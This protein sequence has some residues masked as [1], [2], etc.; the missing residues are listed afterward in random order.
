MD[1]YKRILLVF[2]I[3]L[4]YF[5][6]NAQNIKSLKKSY[7]TTTSITDKSIYLNKISIYYLNNN[8]LDS[9]KIYLNKLILI[10]HKLN[11]PKLEITAYYHLGNIYFSNLDYSTSIKN[12]YKALVLS[13]ENKLT[14]NLDAILIKLALS[15]QEIG[16]FRT[17]IRYAK[18]AL[19]RA[20]ESNNEPN[21]ILCYKILSDN[22]K[23][24]GYSNKAI[25]YI[26]SYQMIAT[27]INKKELNKV[28]HSQRLTQNEL[29]L[30]NAQL[31]ISKLKI[32]SV[33]DSLKI[34]EQLNKEK[35]NKIKFLS[36][37]NLILEQ[38]NKIKQFKLENEKIEKAKSHAIA[39]FTSISLIIA[40]ILLI[41]IFRLFKLRNKMNIELIKLNKTKDKFF[42]I[43]SHDLKSPIRSIKQL[44]DLL[45]K[46]RDKYDKDKR[47]NILININNS[48]EALYNLL[49][50]LLNW[51]R[52]QS[53]KINFSPEKFDINKRINST[54]ALLS[55]NSSEKNILL[56]NITNE[57]AF[58]Y[59]DKN[60]I[61]TVFRNIMANAIKFTRNNGLVT[62]CYQEVTKF[63]K[64]TITDNGI[65]IKKENL[66]H[67]FEINEYTLS[68]GTEGES[69][70]GLGLILSKE[71]IEKNNGTIKVESV[72]GGG[73]SFIFTIPKV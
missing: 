62:V 10:S 50:T 8:K 27:N 42:S 33:E 73:S 40:F 68:K 37:D 65:G 60:M 4:T 5:G 36:K 49:E 66:N 13:D 32:Q 41:I 15:Y 25:H 67:L 51:S 2:L 46:N 52:S 35:E 53:D 47:K 28:K 12:F 55:S 3:V 48:S 11:N 64:I 31:E 54:I 34:V 72:L 63:Y 14:T 16:R 7:N 21:L 6:S 69:G 59:A 18:R 26:E 1:F 29:N 20:K 58:V 38:E 17:S 70:T 9:A 23:K 45:L 61:D 71:F 24:I 56:K 22:N 19:E 57:E 43:I 30:I 39:T 44:T